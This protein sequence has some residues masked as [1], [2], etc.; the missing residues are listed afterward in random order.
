MFKYTEFK[1]I[2][3]GDKFF[4]NTGEVYIKKSS[5]T[6]VI[7]LNINYHRWFYFSKNELVTP[8]CK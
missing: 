1:N 8:S 4:T 7:G 6:A 5:R 2:E 3:I